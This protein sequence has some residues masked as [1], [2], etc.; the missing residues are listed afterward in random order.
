MR[1]GEGSRDLEILTVA[2]TLLAG[3]SAVLLKLGEYFSNNIISDSISTPIWGLTSILILELL[4][5]LLFLLIKGS[6]IWAEK[7]NKGFFEKIG[8]I[9]GS[10]IFSVPLSILIYLTLGVSYTLLVSIYKWELSE[11]TNYL[12]YCLIIAISLI[13]TFRDE[14][15]IKGL[16]EFFRNESMKDKFK[17]IDI[18]IKSLP[19]LYFKFYFRVLWSLVSTFACL[20]LIISIFMASTFLLT[21]SYSMDIINSPDANSDIMTVEIIDN[22][23]P[24]GRCHIDLYRLNESNE[25]LFEKI[26][27]II[28]NESAKNSST[29]IDGAKKHGIYYVSI[30]T[31]AIPPDDYLLH[32]EVTFNKIGNFSLF[33]RKKEDDLVFRIPVN[34]S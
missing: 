31:S 12:V 8:N 10:A 21:G 29:Y 26:D 32:S 30:N 17:K 23:I 19:K 3:I 11:T 22:G 24:S 20:V 28:L 34:Y 7:D 6:S 9:L 1:E 16:K 14:I 25:R 13:I 2:I 33:E 15:D 18:N 5:I 27:T 4:L